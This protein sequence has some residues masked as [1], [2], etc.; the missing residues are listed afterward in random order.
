MTDDNFGYPGLERGAI[1][2][3][4]QHQPDEIYVSIREPISMHYKCSKMHS[5]C[6]G[7]SFGAD[8]DSKGPTQTGLVRSGDTSSSIIH[9]QASKFCSRRFMPAVVSYSLHRAPL[10]P[11]AT[12]ALKTAILVV[13]AAVLSAFRPTPTYF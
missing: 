4:D 12:M 13:P 5:I 10:Q 1:D 6:G 9:R 2:G 7:E 8:G 3:G 11:Y